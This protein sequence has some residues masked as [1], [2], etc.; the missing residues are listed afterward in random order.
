MSALYFDC[1]GLPETSDAFSAH[2]KIANVSK[3]KSVERASPTH[4]HKAPRLT[5][6]AD[7][8]SASR[9]RVTTPLTGRN[10]DGA[11][12]EGGDAIMMDVADEDTVVSIVL[13]FEGAPCTFL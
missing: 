7:S 5:R 12:R 10:T 13:K 9:S 11:T 4:P 6:D 3:N 1:L 8:A 2:P